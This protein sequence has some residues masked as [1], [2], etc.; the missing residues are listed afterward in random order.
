MRRVSAKFVPKVLTADQ[1][2][3]LVSIAQDVYKRQCLYFTPQICIVFEIG[4]QK[5]KP[6]D[7]IIWGK[8]LKKIAKIHMRCLIKV[9]CNISVNIMFTLGNLKTVSSQRPKSG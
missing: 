4:S 7:T 8:V 2:D 1:K 5:Y 3:A 6:K 9:N